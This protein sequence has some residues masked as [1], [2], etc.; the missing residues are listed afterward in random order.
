MSLSPFM[1]LCGAGLLAIFSSTI[2]KSPVLPLFATHLGADPAGVGLVAA[3]SAFTGVAVSLPAGL[4]SDRLGRRRLLLF[5]ALVFASAPFLYL[6]VGQIWQ[7]I[8]VRLYHGLA[9]AIFLPVAMALVADL[10]EGARGEKIG[11]FSTATLLGR[12]AA[13]MAGG[14]ILAALAADPGRSFNA[15][16]LLCGLAG[17]LTLALA[18]FLPRG[19]GGQA[20][21]QSWPETLAAFRRVMGNR[22]IVITCLAEAAVLFAYGTFEVF[23]PLYALQVGMGAW[24]VGI[25]L[26]AQVITLA[27]SKPLLGRFSDRHGRAPQVFAGCLLGAVCI[28][29]YPWLTSF[30]PLLALSVLFGLSLSVVTSAS[31]AFIAD[32]CHDQGR[33]S[34]M[35]MLGSIMDLGHTSGPLLGGLAAAWLGLSASFW[36]AA[37]VIGLMALV[38]AGVAMGSPPTGKAAACSG[39][40]TLEE[41]PR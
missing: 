13:P 11:W 8:L 24:E 20:Q 15:V 9:T 19:Q 37:L 38:F 6:L 21:A 34:A 23:L 36:L 40:T 30:W 7:L 3:V 10:H 18:A 33:G 27:L 16:Y 31:A 22:L 32:Q 1:L 28:G 25:F 14:T 29:V 41:R 12:F 39:Q 35:G 2:A 4:L 26:S 17:V 5:S